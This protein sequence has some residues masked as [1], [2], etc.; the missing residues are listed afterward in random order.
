MEPRWIAKK[1]HSRF[2]PPSF[3]WS[4]SSSLNHTRTTDSQAIVD[5]SPGFVRMYVDFV[6]GG[7]A[8]CRG[9]VSTDMECTYL[10]REKK[11]EE[12]GPDGPEKEIT[13]RDSL[14][15]I[16]QDTGDDDDEE[17]DHRGKVAGFTTKYQVA[18]HMMHSSIEAYLNL[19][20][21]YRGFQGSH[22]LLRLLDSRRRKAFLKPK[23]KTLSMRSLDRCSLL[24]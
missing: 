15:G 23:K 4:P 20:G 9:T 24:L 8:L 18:M 3:R 1:D 5:I 13:E 17:E 21:A 19:T 6:I 10:L 16:Y 22:R 11:D 7:I 2:F 14:E 12:E